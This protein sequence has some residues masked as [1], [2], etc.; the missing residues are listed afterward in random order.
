QFPASS[1]FDVFVNVEVPASPGEPLTLHNTAPLHVVPVSG[2]SEVNINAWP[3]VGATYGGEYDPCIQ[4]HP[5]M[6]AEVCVNSVS[7]T[8]GEEKVPTP[9]PTACPPQ[10]CTPTPTV[11]IPPTPTPPEPLIGPS[12]SVAPD[13][14][15]ELSPNGLLGISGSVPEPTPIVVSGND[16]FADAWSVAGLPFVGQQNTTGATLES[17]EPVNPNNC[18]TFLPQEK[19]ATV[20]YSYTPASTGQVTA[21]TLGSSFD[22]V[23]AAYTGNSVNALTVIACDDDTGGVLQSQISFLAMGGTTYYFQAGGFDGLTG[24]LRLTLVPGSGAGAGTGKF[25][26]ISC[27]NLGLTADGCDGGDGDEDDLNALSFGADFG[28]SGPL[29]SFS[30]APGSDGLPGTDVAEQAD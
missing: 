26:R 29:V 28:G 12:F 4:L 2:A 14:P 18:I 13:G 7:I 21:N 1:F 20:W 5:Q 22:T 17:G 16:D 11:I 30:V 25:L 10:V 24:N 8:I 23:L 6:P 27:S 19:G 9:T 15:S 3:P